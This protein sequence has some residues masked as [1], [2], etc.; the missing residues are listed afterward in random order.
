MEDSLYNQIIRRL[1]QFNYSPY[2]S[3]SESYVELTIY[4]TTTKKIVAIS[5]GDTLEQAIAKLFVENLKN[6]FL[7]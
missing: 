3:L 2:I 4:D 6:S 5:L 1:E 7:Q